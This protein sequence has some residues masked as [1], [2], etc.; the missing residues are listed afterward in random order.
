MGAL[1]LLIIVAAAVAG[2][3][4]GGGSGAL[5]L[6]FMNIGPKARQKVLIVLRKYGKVARVKSDKPRWHITWTPA[7]AGAKD[8]ALSSTI[9]MKYIA[10]SNKAK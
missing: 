5:V 8:A 6:N 10:S 1:L 7:S 2:K 9:V 4:G 3:S